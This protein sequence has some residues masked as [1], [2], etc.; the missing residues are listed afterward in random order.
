[1]RKIVLAAITVIAFSMNISAQGFAYDNDKLTVSESTPLPKSQSKGPDGGYFGTG[2]GFG[3]TYAGA[4]IGVQQIFGDQF[5]YGVYAAV[6]YLYELDYTIGFKL[7][8][9]DQLHTS[10]GLGPVAGYSETTFPNGILLPPVIEE[11]NLQGV[12][13]LL[14]YDWFFSE[15]WALCLDAGAAVVIENTGGFNG[16]VFGAFDFGL[17]YAF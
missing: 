9:I 16:Q 17:M 14:G 7:Y 15:K 5:R 6:G 8:Y 11:S 13:F 1:M 4:G 12:S 3:N 2:V 10:I